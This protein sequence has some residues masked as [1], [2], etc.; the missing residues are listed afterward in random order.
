[1]NIRKIHCVTDIKY[2]LL[3]MLFVIYLN[4]IATGNLCCLVIYLSFDNCH[5]RQMVAIFFIFYDC[6]Q[7]YGIYYRCTTYGK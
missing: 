6:F 4:F 3:H 7:I 1:M 5:T 2:Y